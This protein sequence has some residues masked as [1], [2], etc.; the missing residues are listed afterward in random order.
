MLLSS[1][2]ESVG[3]LRD[4]F[5]WL[6][7]RVQVAAWAR[8]KPACNNQAWCLRESFIWQKKTSVFG[9]YENP[10]FPGGRVQSCLCAG[11]IRH[12]R[13][14]SWGRAHRERDVSPA[15]YQLVA[16][17]FVV[18]NVVSASKAEVKLAGD[19]QLFL[20]NLGC[21]LS[22]RQRKPAMVLDWR[23]FVSHDLI[24]S[25]LLKYLTIFHLH[26]VTVWKIWCSRWK[27]CTAFVW[28]LLPPI[29]LSCP[30]LPLVTTDRSFRVELCSYLSCLIVGL[31][32]VFC[33]L[34]FCF[35]IPFRKKEKKRKACFLQII[36]S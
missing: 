26:S 29:S 9:V 28:S 25:T 32:F 13:A 24:L 10:A 19:W 22:Y 23:R 36:P 20:I 33:F 1:F 17:S 2:R 30:H 8:N 15:G 3:R 18:L 27:L 12:H 5:V 4:P 21:C 6:R 31:G 16:F 34:L 7:P 14:R 35:N 11:A